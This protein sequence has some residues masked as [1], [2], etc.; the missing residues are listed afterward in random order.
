MVAQLMGSGRNGAVINAWGVELGT[1]IIECECP[2]SIFKNSSKNG[3]YLYQ[4]KS[5]L[6]IPGKA[7]CNGPASHPHL[8]GVLG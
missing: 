1:G 3:S 6:G 8:T 2:Q 7:T 5:I 4:Y